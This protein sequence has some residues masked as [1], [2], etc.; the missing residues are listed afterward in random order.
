MEDA[1]QA[2]PRVQPSR[3]LLPHRHEL[4]V[5]LVLD[6]ARLIS[7]ISMVAGSLAAQPKES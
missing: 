1:A 3:N 7:L 2:L 6:T 4:T 5:F